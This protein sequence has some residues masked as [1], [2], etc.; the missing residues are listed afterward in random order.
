MIYH[1][2]NTRL[3]KANIQL[4]SI[5]STNYCMQTKYPTVS[6]LVS[7]LLQCCK[8]DSCICYPSCRHY[9]NVASWTHIPITSHCHRRLVPQHTLLKLSPMLWSLVLVEP[10]TNSKTRGFT[11]W[12]NAELWELHNNNWKQKQWKKMTINFLVFIKFIYNI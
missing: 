1:F 8:V 7:H 10:S 6:G 12:L 9:K 5:T 2:K 4:F 3:P 11:K